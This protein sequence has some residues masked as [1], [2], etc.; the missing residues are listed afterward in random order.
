M[1]GL[2]TFDKT[3][4]EYSVAPNDDMVI[5]WRSK[6]KGQ[7]HS[8]PTLVFFTAKCIDTKADFQVLPIWFS[9]VSIVIFFFGVKI[10]I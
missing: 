4:R 1:N 10:I 2:N 7:G 9:A 6:I 3:D 8:R 5:F